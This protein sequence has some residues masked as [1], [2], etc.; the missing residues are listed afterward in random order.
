MI[1][2]NR[3]K[4]LKDAFEKGANLAPVDFK[5][6]DEYEAKMQTDMTKINTTLSVAQ[7][8]EMK[9]CSR[10]TVYNNKDLFDWEGSRIIYNQK[11]KSFKSKTK[12]VPT[13]YK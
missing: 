1:T 12:H 4:M 11:A 9:G 8:A 13:I 3:Y 7:I 6:I 5:N 2:E 10:Q